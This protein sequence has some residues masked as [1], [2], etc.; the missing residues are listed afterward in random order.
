VSELNAYPPDSPASIDLPAN[1]LDLTFTALQAQLAVW[2]ERP[3]RAGQL[4]KWLY[5]HLA[6]DYGQMS[7]LPRSL[8]ERLGRLYRPDPLTPAYEQVSADG[9]TRK[10]L[11]RL[12]DGE[13][14]ESVLMEYD[15]R[16]TVCV[17]SQ[18]GCPLGCAFCATG[19]SG[20]IRD[21]SPGEIVAQPLYF[22]RQL[23]AQNLPLSNVVLM[24]MGEPLLNYDAVWQ[25]VETWNDHSGFDLGARRITISTVG[26][27][28]GIQRLAEESLQVGLAVSLHAADDALRDQLVPLNRSYPLSQLIP[29][30]REYVARTRRRITIEYALIDG[31]ND[32]T[33]H[34]H[35]LARA[36]RGMLCHVN[37]IPLNPTP[38]SVYRPSP[39]PQVRAFQRTL[40]EKQI[41]TTLRVRR[42][43][44]IQA[45]CG[46]LRQSQAENSR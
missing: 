36:L 8:R 35:Q 28:P 17:S 23:R 22:A 34:A 19:Q 33:S 5:V 4:W 45:G 41:A 40:R 30:C 13:T 26:Y 12:A 44:D 14:I 15:Q 32:S 11:F 31:V 1:I 25:A 37:L 9:W 2:S 7:D 42:G 20:F 38:S 39:L 10:V 3:F 18:V 21:L 29:A 46:Q 43:I 27:V 6:T 16:R 24:G